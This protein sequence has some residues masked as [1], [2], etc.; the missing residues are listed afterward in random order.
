M[1]WPSAFSIF[2]LKYLIPKN[3]STERLI[4]T[5]WNIFRF[6]AIS[7]CL[8]FV[9][10]LLTILLFDF[11]HKLFHFDFITSTN[12]TFDSFIVRLTSTLLFYS[13]QFFIGYLKECVAVIRVILQDLNGLKR[14]KNW[15]HCLFIYVSL[16]FAKKKNKR[17]KKKM[18]MIQ[19]RNIPLWFIKMKWFNVYRNRRSLFSF[20]FLCFR[21]VPFHF[22]FYVFFVVRTLLLS[23]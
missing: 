10:L 3:A 6:I 11:H 13:F 2:A 16:N 18:F 23:K 21:I 12:S 22:N 4:S 19:S 1:L 5:N 7:Y 8:Q 14:K 17:I 9:L 20:S 15:F